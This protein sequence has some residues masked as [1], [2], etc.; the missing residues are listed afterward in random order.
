VSMILIG[1]LLLFLVERIVN[2][3]NTTDPLFLYVLSHIC[4]EVPREISLRPALWIY[5][6]SHIKPQLGRWDIP[7]PDYICQTRS[8][9]HEKH[10]KHAFGLIIIKQ[11]HSHVS[12]V[13]FH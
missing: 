6:G 9:E 10:E 1:C 3:L 5:Y 2:N 7:S 13:K 4:R 12:D 11:S 8:V